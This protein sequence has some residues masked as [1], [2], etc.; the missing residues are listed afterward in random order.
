MYSSHR[1]INLSYKILEPV[2]CVYW[3]FLLVHSPMNIYSTLLSLL[4]QVTFGHDNIGL[5]SL[6]NRSEPTQWQLFL[7]SPF[8]YLAK[9][10][11]NL[12]Q[13]RHALNPKNRGIKVICISDTH[14]TEPEM[15]YGDVL[16]HA[17]DAT[18]GG[19][20]EEMSKALGWLRR[21][22]HPYIVVIAGNHDILRGIRRPNKAGLDRYYLP[23]G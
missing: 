2:L 9:L 18:Q 8:Q 13:Q 11:Y 5:N 22:P 12:Q 10:L 15:P 3:A 19:T 14:N 17:G 21:L 1:S 20:I 23:A 16:I 7:A 4:E 6:S